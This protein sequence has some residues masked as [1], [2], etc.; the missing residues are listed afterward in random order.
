VMLSQYPCSAAN[1]TQSDKTNKALNQFYI[2]LDK[3]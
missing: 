2:V 3:V 1:I